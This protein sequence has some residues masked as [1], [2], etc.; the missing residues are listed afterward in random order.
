MADTDPKI[1]ALVE[2][3]LKKNPDASVDALY[4]LAKKTSRAVG[5]MSLRQ[6]HARYPLQ[7]KRRAGA[8]GRKAKPRKSAAKTR[9][10]ATTATAVSRVK[11]V[12]RRGRPPGSKNRRKATNGA[13]KEAVRAAF[14]SFAADLTAAEGRQDEYR[15][16]AD[17]DRYVD[18]AMKAA[19]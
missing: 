18:A 1:M 13:G 2:A 9:R 4:S 7:I 12:V 11:K 14:L 15:V 19:R 3:E 16:I 8:A 10:K 5:R 17:I 6:F